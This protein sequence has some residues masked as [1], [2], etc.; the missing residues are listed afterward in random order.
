MRKQHSKVLYP[1]LTLIL[2]FISSILPNNVVYGQL[3]PPS[4]VDVALQ[5]QVD[6][7]FQL[8]PAMMDSTALA[9]VPH[10]IEVIVALADTNLVASVHLKLV[11]QGNG[12]TIFDGSVP[13]N[14][15][16]ATTTAYTLIRENKVLYLN[17]GNHVG[18]T[19]FHAEAYTENGQ[20]GSSTTVTN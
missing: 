15:T 19:N 5:A 13:F 6:S 17:F 10:T 2:F 16:T 14:P 20:G 11:N 18:S 1:F 7:T 12:A 9:S 3:F 4:S 8:D